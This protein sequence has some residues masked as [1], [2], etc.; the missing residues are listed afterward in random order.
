MYTIRN[1]D[2]L[3]IPMKSIGAC[4]EANDTMTDTGADSFEEH[5]PDI[6]FMKE[7]GIGNKSGGSVCDVRA[8]ENR[9]GDCCRHCNV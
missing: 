7:K 3:V 4:G 5:V 8:S 1:Y 2:L 9:V 6:V